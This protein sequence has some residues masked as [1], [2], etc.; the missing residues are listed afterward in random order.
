VKVKLPADLTLE[1][2]RARRDLA[3]RDGALELAFACARAIDKLRE[4]HPKS[5]AKQRAALAHALLAVPA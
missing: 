2:L 4:K 1:E 5:Y 3:Q